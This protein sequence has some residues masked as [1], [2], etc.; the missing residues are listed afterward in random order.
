MQ[1]LRVDNLSKRYGEKLLFEN[2]SFV[3]NKDE[4]VALIAAN[5]TGKSS[6]IRALCGIEPADGGKIDF[7]KDIRVDFLQQEPDINPDLSI[8]ENILFSDNPATKAILKYEKALLNTEDINAMTDAMQKMDATNA[9]DYE[10]RV[11]EILFKLKIFDFNK[12]AGVLS[13]G[14]KKRVALAKILVNEPDFLILDEPTNHLD[15]DMIEWL[16]VFLTKLRVTI[17]MVTHDRYFLENICDKIIELE[18]GQIYNYSGNY[19]DYV[20]AKEARVENEKSSV[21]KAKNLMRT[22]LEWMRR[23]PKARGTKS[24]S[25]ISSFYELEDKA[26]KRVE[27]KAIEFDIAPS[28]L[29]SKIVELHNISKSYGER[30]LFEN[31]SYKF[32]RFDKVGIVGVNGSGK[33][34]FLKIMTGKMESDTGKVVIGETI[35]FGLYNQDGLDISGEKRLIEVVREKGEY[36]PTSGGGKITAAQLLEKFLFPRS[37]HFVH[38][39]KLSGGE[40]R[41]LYLLTVLIENPN[42]L[43]LDE[44]TNDLDIITLQVLETFLSEYK[45]CLLI[46]SHDRYFMDKLVEHVFVFNEDASISDF[47]GNYTQYRNKM[48]EEKEL[49]AEEKQNAKQ[50]ATQKAKALV[51]E[52]KPTATISYEDRKLF[53]KLEK[54]IEKLETK[55]K[56]I[57]AK[58][59]EI[60]TD[61]EKIAELQKEIKTLEE[62]IDE[63]SMLWMELGEKM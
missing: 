42:F 41:R 46:V 39:S 40:R 27:Q 24:K 18:N 11:K 37:Q 4:K 43:I 3:I 8:L 9:W 51:A 29:G 7:H 36:I 30:T 6:M 13:G 62:K 56:A 32:Q 5:G 52:E 53:N 20:I 14:E 63:K 19:T 54:E 60:S 28:R 59:A 16:E 25:R 17:L 38:V 2:L 61:Y 1:Y 15:L 58:M 48:L 10:A 21:L 34:T 50:E 47:P 23:S 35:K 45:G 12:I 33:S 55:K 31:F 22:E 26:K 57:H 49:A 44:P